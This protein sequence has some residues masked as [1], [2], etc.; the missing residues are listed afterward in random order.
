MLFFKPDYFKR[1]KNFAMH[2]IADLKWEIYCI[3]RDAS[4]KIVSVGVAL[5]ILGTAMLVRSVKEEELKKELLKMETVSKREE[6]DARKTLRSQDPEKLK[7]LSKLNE[8]FSE[9]AKKISAG[10]ILVSEMEDIIAKGDTATK[11]EKEKLASFIPVS[12]E[13]I[14]GL[15]EDTV[16]L[17]GYSILFYQLEHRTTEVPKSDQVFTL[18][19]EYL[20]MVEKTVGS[21]RITD[22]KI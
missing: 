21:V 5:G 3:S 4:T 11:R 13:F 20:K 10:V 18:L 2:K 15:R 12:R 7:Q 16:M 14:N 17:E 8:E 1:A 9:L 19:I 6:A 22:V